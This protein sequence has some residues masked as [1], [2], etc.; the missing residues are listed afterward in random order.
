MP[1]QNEG[2]WVGRLTMDLHGH[3]LDESWSIH[4]LA[5][6]YVKYVCSHRHL[7]NMED[8]KCMLCWNVVSFFSSVASTTSVYLGQP[9][10]E[11]KLE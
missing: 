4:T 6:T 5:P 8:E 7:M 2:G 11:E 1:R 10:R 3:R 9:S